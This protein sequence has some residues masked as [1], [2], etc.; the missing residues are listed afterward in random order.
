MR[1]TKAKEI[2][3]LCGKFGCG[4]NTY[5]RAKKLYTKTSCTPFHAV[6]TSKLREIKLEQTL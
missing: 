5:K 3:K 1:G 2:R 4:D 6:F